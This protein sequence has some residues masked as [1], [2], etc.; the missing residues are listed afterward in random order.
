[1]VYLLDMDIKSIQVEEIALEKEIQ[2]KAELLKAYK[3]VRLDLEK[4][5]NY[6]QPQV[7][8]EA[9]LEKSA[10]SV[11]APTTNTA[12]PTA[13]EKIARL[14]LYGR[15]TRLVRQAINSMT[16]PYSHVE[17]GRWIEEQSS[18]AN[19][20]KTTEICSVLA[21]LKRTNHIEIAAPGSGRRPDFFKPRSSSV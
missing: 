13:S 18:G 12:T 6:Q 5:Q 11:S 8:R 1:M 3:A 15:N 20:L 7:P 9:S 17:I 21:R 4:K 14:V 2:A 16:T 19:K 10:T